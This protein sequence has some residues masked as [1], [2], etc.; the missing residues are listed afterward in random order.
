MY[1]K[2]EIQ[3]SSDLYSS[4]LSSHEVLLSGK[5]NTHI[6]WDLLISD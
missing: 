2:R 1:L 3:N 5:Y 6:H 4:M